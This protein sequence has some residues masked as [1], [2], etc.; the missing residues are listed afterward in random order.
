MCKLSLQL[1][2][3]LGLALLSYTAM[4]D[5]FVPLAKSYRVEV[6]NRY[7]HN[8]DSFTQGLLYHRGFL[9]ESVGLR[10]HSAL[11]KVNL[12]TGEIL[13]RHDLAKKRFAEGLALVSDEKSEDLLV[14]LTYTSGIGLVYRRA[15]LT[16]VKTFTIKDQGWGLTL[17][18]EHLVMTDGS[19]WLRFLDKQTFEVVKSVPVV[20]ENG[21]V[22]WINELE[23]VEG[24]LLANVWKTHLIGVIEVKSGKVVAYIDLSHLRKYVGEQAGDLNGI[25]YDQQGQR[26]FVTG[27]NWPWLFEVRLKADKLDKTEKISCQIV[28]DATD[29]LLNEMA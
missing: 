21:P 18:G 6:V 16:P 10:G 17:V 1:L 26:L 25:A 5:M 27:K 3:W 11:Y 19:H 8:K 9:Y 29:S 13:Q 2:T 22:K 24:Y 7:P 20:D 14:Q 23:Y 4:A 28:T 15:S 12:H